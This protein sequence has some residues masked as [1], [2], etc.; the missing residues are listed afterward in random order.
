MAKGKKQKD[1]AKTKAAADASPPA[2]VEQ[3]V[4]L[5]GDLLQYP[6]R[7]DLEG[8]TATGLP[9]DESA[10]AEDGDPGDPS[11]QGDKRDK[12]S[13]A[14]VVDEH[15]RGALEAVVFASDEPL[16]TAELAK[17]VSANKKEVARV[18]AVL[19]SDYGSRGIRLE[20]IAGGWLFRTHPVYAP[21]VRDLTKQKPVKL[22][23]AQLETLAILAYRQPITRPE[24]DD[25]RGV[26]SGPVLK[27][28][29]DRD[30]I[31]ILGK[32]EEAGRPLLYG[33]TT[34]FLEFFG[35]KSLKDLPTLKEFT[36]LSEESQKAYEDEL[37][38]RYAAMHE[39]GADANA[40]VGDTAE[41]E[42]MLV[43][44]TTETPTLTAD[45]APLDESAEAGQVDAN[46]SDEDSVH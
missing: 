43:D 34:Q 14:N 29:L 5:V 4:N 37:G 44:A 40:P 16:T 45:D 7:D 38:E 41:T 11:D 31:R 6:I 46:A 24:I 25:I 26:D 3:T 10:P 27:V 2:D 28:L 36:E 32:K 21:F 19:A 17:I 33:T 1:S 22:S 8:P 20:E 39:D 13:K 15:L 35:L 23:R 42:S 12:R 30:L 9:E 18:L